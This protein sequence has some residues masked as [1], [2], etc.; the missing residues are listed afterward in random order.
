MNCNSYDGH[1][2]TGLKIIDTI[3]AFR[4]T[5]LGLLQGL[6]VEG[7]ARPWTAIEYLIK[8]NFLVCHLCNFS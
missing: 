7:Q 4:L 1:L 6:K 2:Y 5:E 3:T 8:S